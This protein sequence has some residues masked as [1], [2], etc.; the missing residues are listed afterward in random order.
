MIT[1]KSQLKPSLT[2]HLYRRVLTPAKSQ[3]FTMLE[4]L[5]AMMIAFA[6]LMGTLNAMLAAT[7]MQVK[8]ER[9]AQATY[10]IQQDLEN[11]QAQA[12]A[13]L[14]DPNKC[15]SVFSTSYAGSLNTSN[16]S[17][18]IPVVKFESTD[19]NAT[20]TTGTNSL[21][22]TAVA[23][24]ITGKSYTMTRTTGGSN[25]NPQILTITYTVQNA[26]DPDA[27]ATLYTEVIPPKALSC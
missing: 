16:A 1:L 21:V 5:A 9:Q 25:T 4:V 12:G 10:W 19:A 26:S 18:G 7:M 3:G 8:A 24:S 15:T 23:T 13:Q 17:T 14:P 20:Y 6:F 11:I 27:I 2:W 22:A